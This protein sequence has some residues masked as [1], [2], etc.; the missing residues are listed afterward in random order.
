M[1]AGRCHNFLLPTFWIVQGINR[2]VPTTLFGLVRFWLTAAMGFWLL[3]LEKL[4]AWFPCCP[5]CSSGCCHLP[6]AQKMFL[7]PA[8]ELSN[9][10]P[11]GHISLLEQRWKARSFQ[12][13]LQGWDRLRESS[14]CSEWF[15]GF[16]NPSPP[17][18]THLLQET[19]LKSQLF[20]PASTLS[21]SV[22]NLYI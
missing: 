6:T 13:S 11:P 21:C 16:A 2:R 7:F 22:L 18:P 20:N 17:L 9:H 19:A 14:A 3:Q 4:L 15:N 10:Q 1:K 5:S 8:A 12:I